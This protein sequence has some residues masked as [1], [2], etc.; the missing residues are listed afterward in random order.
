MQLTLTRLLNT[1]SEERGE[2]KIATLLL[3]L[4]HVH[5]PPPITQSLQNKVFAKDLQAK[6]HTAQSAFHNAIVIL[7]HK[8]KTQ[9]ENFI[10]PEINKKL[11]RIF[12]FYTLDKL[13]GGKKNRFHQDLISEELEN[14]YTEYQLPFS[15]ESNLAD[16]LDTE[17][18]LEIIS[19]MLSDE[20][21]Y[22]LFGQEKGYSDKEIAE[23]LGYK[24][25][26]SVTNSRYRLIQK[27][28]GLF[29]FFEL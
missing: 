13:Q 29:P 23:A 2:E 14:V 4:N 9:K 25:F 26:K 20:Q 8:L 12:A 11:L 22:I 10:Y 15:A 24:N 27:L 1:L 28:Q 17:K 18:A 3:N 16:K 21:K 7:I 19:E 6:K 5:P